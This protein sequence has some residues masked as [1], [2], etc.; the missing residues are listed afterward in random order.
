L[1]PKD[2]V[3][4]LS[5]KGVDIDD[6]LAKAQKGSDYEGLGLPT[7]GVAAK[8][9]ERGILR[10]AGLHSHGRILWKAGTHFDAFKAHWLQNRG[11]YYKPSAVS[12]ERNEG[13]T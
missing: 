6:F 13:I 3:G 9:K 11:N 2:I 8:L 4:A 5:E 12:I 10:K 1:R 7:Q